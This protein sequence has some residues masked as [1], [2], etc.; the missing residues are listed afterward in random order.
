MYKPQS[1]EQHLWPDFLPRLSSIIMFLSKAI[2]TT[3]HPYSFFRSQ[4]TASEDS[5]VLHHPLAPPQHSSSLVLQAVCHIT[6]LC[7]VCRDSIPVFNAARST[8]KVLQRACWMNKRMAIPRI[9]SSGFWREKNPMY[10]KHLCWFRLMKQIV[11]A[12]H[13]RSGGVWV[14]WN[15]R[16]LAFEPSLE[17]KN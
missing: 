2:P 11:T 4:P 7:A 9:P 8:A 3:L 10:I 16:K 15:R 6:D 17:E 13:R 5:H 12:G 14:G 1:F